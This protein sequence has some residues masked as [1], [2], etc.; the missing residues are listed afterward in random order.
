MEAPR[1]KRRI[2]NTLTIDI[3]SDDTSVAPFDMTGEMTDVELTSQILKSVSSENYL[4]KGAHGNVYN[5]IFDDNT[6]CVIKVG[7]VSDSA[8][9]NE[10]AVLNELKEIREPNPDC[11]NR[12]VDFCSNSYNY[13]QSGGQFFIVLQ[14]RGGSLHISLYDYFEDPDKIKS[15][16]N[17]LL[18][19]IK[20]FHQMGFIH[21]DL[22]PKN[23]LKSDDDT[24]IL[25]D[26]G[27]TASKSLETLD[28]I[29]YKDDVTLLYSSPVIRN[30]NN[31]NLFLV[32]IFYDVWSMLLII[33]EMVIGE[34]L[35][36]IYLEEFIPFYILTLDS[37][38]FLYFINSLKIPKEYELKWNQL[39]KC[40]D[41]LERDVMV[42]EDELY[43]VL[44][45]PTEGGKKR[46]KTRRKT[47]RKRKKTKKK[48]KK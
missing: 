20:C 23:I 26:F 27:S 35:Y 4:D 38:D 46:R 42:N 17:G 47:R 18:E 3:P 37:E 22:K 31:D 14:Y 28:K 48:K 5:Y 1:K 9:S 2:M 45:S 12:I 44:V 11:S 41:K 6:H 16:S 29:K 33:T 24:L 8:M 13:F 21:R 39:L 25:I 36:N 34:N 15:L 30:I 10:I 32:G 7:Y 40:R 19:S 43:S